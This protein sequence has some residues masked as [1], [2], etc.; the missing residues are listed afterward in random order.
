VTGLA[1]TTSTAG[2]VEVPL[3]LLVV[4]KAPVPGEAKTRLAA[5]VGDEGAADVAAAALL[6]TLDACESAAPVGR[7]LVALTGDLT[8]AA[9][10]AEIADRLRAW[11]VVAQC[12]GS[13]AERLVH[14]HRSAADVFGSTTL[15]VQIGMDTPQVTA[16]DLHRLAAQVCAGQ[17]DVALGPAEDGGWWGLVTGRAGVAEALRQVPTSRD[18]TGVS[19]RRALEGA[20]LQVAVGHWMRDVDTVE[21]AKAVASAAPS[22][23]FAAAWAATTTQ[24]HR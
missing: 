16:T 9:R 5:G 7:R 8:Y 12:G 20:G 10:G 22:S 4:A 21:D 11:T 15:V 6:D 14:A 3:H 17:A 1:S 24:E 13:F 2:D 19:T 23:R 18:D